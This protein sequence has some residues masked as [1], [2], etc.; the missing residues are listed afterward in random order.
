M[1]AVH[2]E[3]IKA[4]DSAVLSAACSRTS[5]C[6][7]PF[8]LKHQCR[9]F[10]DLD[11]FLER[12]DVDIVTICTPS[13]AHAEPACKAA[14][15]GKHVIVEK[16][17]EVTLQRADQIIEACEANNVRL[18]AV[19]QSRF[20][21]A[22]KLLKRAIEENLFGV[23]TLGSA[24]VRWYRP[25]EY[26]DSGEWRGTIALDGGGALMNQSIHAIDL[27]RWLMGDV[28]SVQSFT[29]MLVHDKIEVEDTAVAILRFTSGALGVI[30]G[31]TGA[32]P[33]YAK[34]IEISGERGTVVLT[35]DR[36]T[37]WSFAEPTELDAQVKMLAQDG[38][39]KGGAADP[40]AI[41]YT[42]HK[43]QFEDFIEAVRKGTP[44]SIDGIEGR[45]TLEVVLAIYRANVQGRR[46]SLPLS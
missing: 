20:S 4:M 23:L 1:A 45:K 22:S 46:V 10:S 39:G 19:F 26:Y 24:Y 21:E 27:L 36:I 8:C 6:L 28:A 31:S 32:Y 9:G 42:G 17:I 41:N 3:A 43:A 18:G 34:R 11:E 12:A 29:D 35:E 30:E 7:E 2:A 38:S 40:M 25:Q 16:P 44:P 5:S 14:E 33:G 15:A 37:E 13:G